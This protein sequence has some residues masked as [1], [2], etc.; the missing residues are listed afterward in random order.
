MYISAKI[1]ITIVLCKSL[2]L[3]RISEIS[4]FHITWRTAFLEP[5]GSWLVSG[6]WQ[7]CEC[8]FFKYHSV[9]I[10]VVILFLTHNLY[11]L[12]WKRYFTTS[13]SIILLPQKCLVGLLLLA[14]IFLP[15]HNKVELFCLWSASPVLLINLHSAAGILFYTVCTKDNFVFF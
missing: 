7:M 13:E 2:K 5:V 11:C 9:V 15:S 1:V 3:T 4:M 6:F 12:L 10:Y 14:F 8:P